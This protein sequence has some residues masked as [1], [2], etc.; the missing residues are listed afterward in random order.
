MTRVARGLA[1]DSRRE[2]FALVSALLIVLVLAVIGLGAAWLAS[3]ERRCS[4]ADSVHTRALLSADAGGEAAINFLRLSEEPPLVTDY[5]SLTVQSV[6]DTP[7]EG[8]QDYA[9]SCRFLGQ[10]PKPGWGI[11][12]LDFEYGVDARGGASTEGRSDV[13][14]IV[15]KLYYQEGY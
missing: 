8:S 13:E 12:W 5:V 1:A 9:Y 4:F 10:R 15:S 14:M 2:G 11:E 7:L 6:G 3:G